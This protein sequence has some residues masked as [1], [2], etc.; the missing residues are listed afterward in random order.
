MRKFSEVLWILNWFNGLSF[1]MQI[2]LG[3]VLMALILTRISGKKA[4]R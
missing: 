4:H 2:M 3:I 1:D